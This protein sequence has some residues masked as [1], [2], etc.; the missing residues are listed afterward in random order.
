VQMPAMG[1]VEGAAQHANA[2]MPSG[3]RWGFRL[4]AQGRT[5]PVPRT[6]Y[7]YVVS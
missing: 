1:R 3:R 5:C 4:A 2:P 7:L 6:K